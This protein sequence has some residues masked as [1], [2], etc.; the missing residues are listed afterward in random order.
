MCNDLPNVRIP[1]KQQI[2][3]NLAKRTMLAMTS[4]DSIKRN[5]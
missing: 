4:A 2:D 5:M 1:Y 3:L